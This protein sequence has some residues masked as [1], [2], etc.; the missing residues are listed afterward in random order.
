MSQARHIEPARTKSGVRTCHEIKILT[1]FIKPRERRV[2]H[3][4]RHLMRFGLFRLINEDGMQMITKLPSVCEPFTVGRP[5]RIEQLAGASVSVSI[6]LDRRLLAFETH[7]PKTQTLV[8]VGDF[9]AVGRPHG[10]VIERR[11]RAKVDFADFA[12]SALVADV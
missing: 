3:P 5:G 11:R 4:V 12:H 7:V 6:H 1:L 10:R 9:L 8:G 2:A